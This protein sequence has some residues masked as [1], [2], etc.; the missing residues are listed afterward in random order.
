MKK[1]AGI[2]L[3]MLLAAYGSYNPA[4][5]ILPSHIKAISI[6]PFVNE[7]SNYGLEERLN[8]VL[9]DEF[10]RDGRI[11]ISGEDTADGVLNGKIVKYILE[12]LTYDENHV[13]VQYKLWILADIRFE[14]LHENKILWEEKNLEGRYNYFTETQP[15]GMTEEDAR[16]LIWENL[17]RDI[18]RR[19]IE[20]YGSVTGISERNA[21][22]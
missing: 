20:G 13:I 22:R 14:D 3:A 2:I 8:L 21:P 15:G 4:T 5:V 7:T 12:P 16:E 19:T 18:V 9:T 1:M 10:L 6:R 11:A 17:S